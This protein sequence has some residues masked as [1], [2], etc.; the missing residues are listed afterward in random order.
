MKIG[1]IGHLGGNCNFTD[2]QTVKTKALVEGLRDKGYSN[3]ILADTYYMRKNPLS[4]VKQLLQVLLKSDKIIVL[5][6]DR[7]RKILFPILSKMSSK[8]EIYHYSIGGRLAKEAAES[9]KYKLQISLFRANWVE[10]K[11]IARELNNMG[12]SNA[13]YLPNFKRIK[14][15][16]FSEVRPYKHSPYHFCMFSRVMPEKG[17][18]DAMR[19]IRHVNE[20]NGENVV[21]LDIYGAVE[22]KY[23][24]RFQWALNNIGGG[25]HKVLWN[26]AA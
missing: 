26:C 8:K 20:K 18:E 13:S 9:D 10:S 19:A 22:N 17:I 11:K 15:M 23:E 21:L 1:V 14:K 12:V 6:S 7:G 3:L 2:G 4:F 16:D 25:L 5:L 24:E